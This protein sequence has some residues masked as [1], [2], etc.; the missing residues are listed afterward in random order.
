MRSKRFH[1]RLRMVCTL[2]L[3]SGLLA[4]SSVLSLAQ[5]ASK[6]SSEWR[7]Y[8]GDT[9]STQYSPLNQITATNFKDLKTAWTWKSADAS[10]LKANPK[11]HTWAWEGTPLMV[12]GV[13]YV[14]TSLSQVCAIDPA[15]GTTLWTYDPETWKNGLP[16]N[17]GFVHRGVAYWGDKK[18]PR[19]LYG[20]GD[21]YLICL[22]AKTGKP[23]ESFGKNGR[24]DLTEGLGRKVNR[25]LYGVSSPPV[26]CRDTVV[27]GASILDFPMEKELPPGDVRGFD[28]RTGQQKW[29]FH[30][31]PHEGEY[32]NDTWQKNSWKS[33][34]AANVWTMMSADEKLGY[35]YLPFSTPANDYYGVD[36]PGNGLFGESLVCVEATTGKRIWHFQMVHHGLW[37]YDLPAAPNLVDITVGGKRIKAV[38]QVT[39]QGF[40]FVFD[41]V[42][43]KPIFPIEERPVP[44][45]T[46]PD[47]VTSPTQP[48]PTKPAPF[49]RQGLTENDLVDFTPE[50]HEE[51]LKI[52]TDYHLG[53]LFTPPATDKPTVIMPGVAGGANWAGAAFDPETGKLYVPS[54]TIPFGAIVVKSPLPSAKFVGF[55]F[56]LPTTKAGVPL[57]KPP[58]ARITAI[59]LNKGDHAWMIP[60]GHAAREEFPAE[61]QALNLPETGRQARGHILLTKTLLVVGL[62]GT[63]QRAR[64]STE[65]FALLADFEIKD[66]KLRAYDKATGKLVGEITLPRNLTGAPMTYQFNGK[67]YI[68]FPTGGANLPAELIALALP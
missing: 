18:S 61:V 29:S 38:A 51:A 32:G 16:P 34:G 3:G 66:A 12:N 67:Q 15:T 56:P 59:N 22:D 1:P 60:M 8:A 58:Y 6:P 30:S 17:H 53:Q 50:L 9:A 7:S 54:N 64:N 20:T 68:V 65:G 28:V 39:K 27:V 49:E 42:T 14:S 45:S 46:V 19:I 36:R 26:I 33:T 62:E 23:I 55:S 40:C 31:V 44:Q 2:S 47:E 24:V 63:T 48:F 10:I 25:K 21:G 37:D 41:R 4:V 43:G 52:L 57:F 35:V 5:S 13:L 11:L